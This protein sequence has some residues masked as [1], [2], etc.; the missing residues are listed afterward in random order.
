MARRRNVD[1]QRAAAVALDERADGDLGEFERI[2]SS[3]RIPWIVDP[4]QEAHG[5]RERRV[6]DVV[7]ALVFPSETR[8]RRAPRTCRVGR[9]RGARRDE[10]AE[11]RPA[12]PEVSELDVP[13]SRPPS[14]NDTADTAAP[15][16]TTSTEDTA[17]R[18]PSR[19]SASSPRRAFARHHPTNTSAGPSSSVLALRASSRLRLR[20]AGGSG[21]ART[22]APPRA[23]PPC[24]ARRAWR[25][26]DEIRT[27]REDDSRCYRP[28]RAFGRND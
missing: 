21:A 26:D 25:T 24:R 1:S 3:L 7:A 19:S 27:R 22:P 28:W 2:R 8:F 14:S 23:R 4:R 11:H 10:R 13:R 6:V 20:S 16:T 9:S 18:A 17:G 12:V 15:A 5:T